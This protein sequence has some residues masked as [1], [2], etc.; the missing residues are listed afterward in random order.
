MG[1]SYIERFEKAKEIFSKYNGILRCSQANRLGIHS[2]VLVQMVDK[3]ILV[4]EGRGIYRLADLPPLSNPD[5]VRVSLSIP[6]GVICLIS[7]LNFHNLTTQIPYRVY[8]SLPRGT[9]RPQFEH[10]PLDIIWPINKVYSS[11]IDEHNIDGVPVKIY[12]KEKTVA[13]CFRYRKKIGLSIAI[14]ALKDYLVLHDKN[15]DKL[16]RYARVDDVDDV[17]TPYVRAIV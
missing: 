15:L 17:I 1:S 12:C 11:G 8:L 16:F 5:F 2:T 9:K 13:D 7:A 3:G 4:K 14:E 10:P 6:N